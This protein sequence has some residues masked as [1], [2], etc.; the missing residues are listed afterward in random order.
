[1]NKLKKLKCYFFGHKYDQ[2]A[3]D[4]GYVHCLTCNISELREGEGE[5]FYSWR[6]KICYN[7]KWTVIYKIEAIKW[8][9]KKILEKKDEDSDLPF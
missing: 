9:I 1:M 2:I 4:H 6:R 5:E 8:K 3:L 7:W